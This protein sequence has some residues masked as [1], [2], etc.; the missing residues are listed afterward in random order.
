MGARPPSGDDGRLERLLGGAGLLSLRR[1]MREYFERLDDGATSSGDLLL[2]RLSPEEREALALLSGRPFRS[3]RS[4]RID[5]A[6]L[7][8]ALRSAGI[9]DSLRAAL[10][11][12]DG[13]IVSRRS[14]RAGIEAEWMSLPGLALRH[15][16]LRAWLE[17]PEAL[18]R[19]RRLSRQSPETA[20]Q[21]LGRADL[22]LERLPAP[23][24]ARSQLAAEVLGNAHALDH[25]EPTAGIVLAVWRSLEDAA[26]RESEPADGE[27]GPE[28]APEAQ[29]RTR[30]IWARAGVFVNEL[31]RPA[32]YLNLPVAGG[33]GWRGRP[34]EPGYA[35][36]RELVRSPPA[37][38]VR[39]ETVFVSENPNVVAIA[40]DRLGAASRPLVSTDGMPAAA[41]RTLL[42]QLAWAGARLAY[43]GDFDWPGVRIGNHVVR[44]WQVDPWR[45]SAADYE[46][47]IGSPASLREPLRGAPV[48]ASWDGQLALRMAA[49]DVAIAEEVVVAALLEDLA[50]R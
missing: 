38:A 43:H 26:A 11:S 1:R 4:A 5:I 21:L 28:E 13:P 34:G 50:R 18:A 27:G 8:L 16:G 19:L 45:F 47:A 49:H 31:S 32:L 39:G 30:D 36:L 40:A 3:A 41:Q 37:W 29:E 46:A 35:S 33:D 25:P 12:L 10:E 2:A 6:E 17:T 15:R 7:D 22:V 24:I 44:M 42:T 20:R 14:V 23:G 48:R 9:S